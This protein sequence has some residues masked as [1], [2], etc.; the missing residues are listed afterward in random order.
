MFKTIKNGKEYITISGYVVES[1]K[2]QYGLIKVYESHKISLIHI[3]NII[4]ISTKT[5]FN[6]SEPLMITSIGTTGN[7]IY[8]VRTKII[9]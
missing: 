6:G 8:N 2:G 3:S 1:K 4:S 9:I 7:K 5:D